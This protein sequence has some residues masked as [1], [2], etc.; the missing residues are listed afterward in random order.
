MHYDKIL[1]LCTALRETVGHGYSLKTFRQ[2]LIAALIVSLVAL[3]L[4][5][6]LS[7]A[8]GLPPQY[9][10]YTAIV[11]GILTPLLGGSVMQVSGPTAAFVVIIAPIVAEHGLRGIVI[12]EIMAGIMLIGLAWA[13]LGRFIN[14]VPYPVTTGFTA[15]I[16]VVLGTLSLNDLLGLGIEKLEGSFVVKVM[17]LIEH[18]PGARWPE[19]A[20]GVL[21]LAIMFSGKRVT[22]RV[23]SILLGICAATLLGLAFQY[24]GIDYATIGNRF[25]FETAEGIGH[26][27]PPMLPEFYDFNA[28]GITFA[29]IKTLF[30][31]AVVIAALAALESLL[32]ASVADGLARTRHE[33]NAE[34]AAIGVANMAS[35]FFAGIPAT[36]AIA[37][38]TT[39]IKSGARTPLA[40]SMHAVFI[41][42]YMLALAPMIAYIPMAS[43]AALLL[44]IAYNMSHYQQFLRIIRIA[45]R[46]DVLV[47]LTC[48]GL[49]VFVDMV[50]GVT[51]GV[52]L[53]ALLFI[54]SI[55]TI[56]EV[57]VE[58]G[59]GASNEKIPPNVMVFHI[60]GPLFFA[61]VERV[62]DRTS[63]LRRRIDTLI[64]DME[65]V[66]LIDM[67]GL[68]AV[69]N[70]LTSDALSGKQIMLCA[71]HDILEKILQKLAN[72][73]RLKISTAPNVAE[74]LK[75]YL[76]PLAGVPWQSP[77]HAK[78]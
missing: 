32:S 41:L 73:T 61:T 52:M 74:A 27:I 66:P 20:I 70:L 11:A 39:N 26:G 33:P 59:G 76:S 77:A 16:A 50:A 17:T 62:I 57:S 5:M 54:Q 12:A 28:G 24:A 25:T 18:L 65:H 10:L 21:S 53:A 2:D 14:F 56:T 31:P 13:R 45:P 7:I 19:V 55:A 69:K 44:V 8:V 30:M 64:L 49:T 4:A 22:R 67:T 46:A 38:T 40:A 37:R 15:G 3:P 51:V 34:L 9:G 35:G 78:R 1:P 36:G 60:S 58:E 42:L 72:E 48:F 29:E 63:F 68:V 71:S 75:N 47:L 43:L 23:P 6:A